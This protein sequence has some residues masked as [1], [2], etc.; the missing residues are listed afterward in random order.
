[1]APRRMSTLLLALLLPFSLAPAT[2]AS[3][4]DGRIDDAIDA[5]GGDALADL[6]SLRVVASGTRWTLDEGPYPGSGAA[7]PGPYTTTTAIDVTADA[8]RL[9]TDLVSYFVFARTLAEVVTPAGG[10][11]DGQDSNF[12]PPFAAPMLTDRWASTRL[13]QRLLYPHLLLLDAVAEPGSVSVSGNTLVFDTGGAPL[14]LTLDPATGLPSRASTFESD[15][16]RRDVPLVVKYRR[17]THVGGLAFPMAVV[18]SYDGEV[19]QHERRGSVE[20][21]V[22]LNSSL[23]EF[24]PGVVPVFD[25]DLEQRGILRHQ[26]LQSFAALGFPRDGVQPFVA[27][28][29]L[30]PGVYHLTGGSHNS[31]AVVQEAG[32][33]IV[34]APLDEVR[35]AAISDWVDANIGLPISHVVPSHHHT[36]HSAGVRQLVAT[37]AVAVIHEDAERF[38]RS[39]FRARSNLVP[40]GIARGPWPPRIE[41]VPDGG[42]YVIDDPQNPV[43]IYTIESE[44]AS[45][46]VLVEAGGVLFVVD[47]YNPGLPLTPEADPILPRV[48]ELGLEIDLVAGGH[49]GTIGWDDFVALFE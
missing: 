12:A 1:M 45:D 24:P 19:V 8:Q 36:D 31:L 14:T 20:V 33:T 13:H 49:G 25:P 28:T 15:P 17:W 16:L 4:A 23:F 44:H 35:V 27:G 18:V 48:T 40:D 46:L 22:D 41:T 42:S 26:M 7:A 32:V 2:L 10:F 30:A 38:F 34:E 39:V 21:N 43:S 37:G 47:I 9:D 5:I 29:E 6:E 11:V 3:D